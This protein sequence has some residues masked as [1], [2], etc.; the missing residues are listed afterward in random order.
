MA[1]D[2]E[3]QSY[4]RDR[5]ASE[6]AF[7]WLS[8]SK[9]F[10]PF[11]EPYLSPTGNQRILH[12]G[13][14]TSDLHVCLR[15]RG[16]RDVTN[17]DYE[18]L[19]LDRGREMEERA[20]GDVIMKYSVADVTKTLGSFDVHAVM[21]CEYYDIVVDKST[22]DAVACGGNEALLAMARCVRKCLAPGAV[23]ISL[24]YSASRFDLGE[25]LFPFEVSVIGRIPTAKTKATDP[26]VYHWCYLLRPREMD[27]GLAV[28]C[29]EGSVL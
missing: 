20:F 12:L 28:N 16:Y 24:S 3:K 2:F 7:E 18:P 4:W 10:I 14:G 19:A 5:F 15:E 26:D 23:W 29:Q 6:T 25:D 22:V 1:A 17:V 8:P 13:S 9:T 11:I 21:P 27:G